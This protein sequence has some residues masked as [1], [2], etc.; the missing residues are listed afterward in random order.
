[1]LNEMESEQLIERYRSLMA[2]MEIAE[3]DSHKAEVREAAK[4]LR[5][6]W[7]DWQGEDSLNEMA[8]GAP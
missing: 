1:M 4:R 8:F 7:K 3:H 2:Q 6:R 5:D